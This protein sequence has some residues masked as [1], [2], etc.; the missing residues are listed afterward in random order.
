MKTVYVINSLEGGGAERV[1]VELVSSV[2]SEESVVG[3]VD[4]VLLDNKD[5]VYTLPDSVNVHRIGLNFGLPLISPLLQFLSFLK[6]IVSLKP[7]VLIGFL[8]RANVMCVFAAKLTGKRAVISER[9]NTVGRLRG[10][11]AAVKRRFVAFA[12]H[13]ADLVVAVS[14]G[15][16]RCLINDIGIPQSKVA[17]LSNPVNPGHITTLANES[18][19]DGDENDKRLVAMG[20]LVKSKGFDDLIR[21]YHRSGLQC[22]LT[23]L[24]EGPERANLQTLVQE[25]SVDVELPGFV[26]NPYSYIKSANMFILSSH[27]EG[28]PNAL[29]EAMALSRPLIATNCQDGPSEILQ[30]ED[31][32]PK[33]EFVRTPYGLMVNVA[34]VPALA[35]ALVFL[36]NNREL[37]RE[38][39]QQA[40]RRIGAYTPPEFVRNFRRLMQS[41]CKGATAN[42]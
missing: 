12:Y 27:L 30:H 41:V 39:G 5:D 22:G 11:L 18:L 1:F 14:K 38:L 40:F 37:Q 36:F 42:V 2:S 19:L 20:R 4:V 25:L 28:F 8:T 24:G 6:L 26:A 23:I 31:A 9:S 3:G 32:I 16:A 7:D 29:L 15:V 13:R 33:G 10:R 35:N 17:I 21:A 34:D